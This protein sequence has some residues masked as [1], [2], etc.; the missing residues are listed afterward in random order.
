MCSI[1]VLGET[2]S[3]SQPLDSTL[4]AESAPAVLKGLGVRTLGISGI[5]LGAAWPSSR[6][7]I[8]YWYMVSS[9]GNKKQRS[10]LE[11][12]DRNHEGHGLLRLIGLQGVHPSEDGY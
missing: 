5:V 4:V 10:R 11:S 1:D 9:G 7:F 12:N 8:C 6:V 2:S 3:P